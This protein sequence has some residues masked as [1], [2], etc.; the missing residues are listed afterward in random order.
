MR[1]N[2]ENCTTLFDQIIIILVVVSI[3]SVFIS[4]VGVLK[5]E[6]LPDGKKG[7]FFEIFWPVTLVL[8]SKYL[9]SKGKVWRVVLLSSLTVGTASIVFVNLS[10][11]CQV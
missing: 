11:A 7:L 1:I 5:N 10:G 4:L 3:I 6:E 8:N 2:F 9:S